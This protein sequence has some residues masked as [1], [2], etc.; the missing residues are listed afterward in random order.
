[1]M[2]NGSQGNTY[3]QKRMG[4]EIEKSENKEFFFEWEELSIFKAKGECLFKRNVREI[5]SPEKIGENRIFL[6]RG[7]KDLY[8][9]RASPII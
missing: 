7:G 1:M 4:G 8:E 6:E 5:I 3:F 2:N 9:G